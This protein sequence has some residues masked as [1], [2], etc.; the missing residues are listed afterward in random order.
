LALGQRV[1]TAVAGITAVSG[2]TMDWN[3]TH[4]FNPAWTPHAKFHDALTI[5][6][7][8]ML[9]S[10]SLYFLHR[11][12]GSREDNRDVGTLL[13]ALFWAGLGTSAFFPGAEGLESEFPHLVPRVKGVWINERF[14][15]ALF[16]A[17]IGGAYVLARREGK[18]TGER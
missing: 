17:V 12:R 8:T 6:L 18:E 7:G 3:R 1:L 4:L 10:A 15:S 9:G 14:A 11:R 2:F 13:P 16:L 5:S